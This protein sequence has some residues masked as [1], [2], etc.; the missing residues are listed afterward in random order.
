MSELPFVVT[1]RGEI[2]SAAPPG[3]ATRCQSSGCFA[4]PTHWVEYGRED[5][6]L[7]VVQRWYVW[8]CEEHMP[9]VVLG[10]VCSRCLGSGA[11]R[12]ASGGRLAD[13]GPCPSCEGTGGAATWP[14]G[15]T[16]S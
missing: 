7:P 1:G 16:P 11:R 3:H 12:D 10:G 9:E 13:T 15:R 5:P 4:R 14:L 8:W 6:S 2:P